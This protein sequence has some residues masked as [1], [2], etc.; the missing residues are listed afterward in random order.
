MQETG[1]NM[2]ASE[3]LIGDRGISVRVLG[4]VTEWRKADNIEQSD[5][6]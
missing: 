2:V 6:G 5:G 1:S 3:L 4:D